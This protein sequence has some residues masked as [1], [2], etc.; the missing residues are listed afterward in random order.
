M[1]RIIL[2]HQ[3]L[4]QALRV[5]RL[6][7]RPTGAP[8]ALWRCPMS[9]SR[10]S[11]VAAWLA[12]VPGCPRSLRRLPL[13][14]ARHTAALALLHLLPAVPTK[15]CWAKKVHIMF[16]RRL[17]ARALQCLAHST[18]EHGGQC[19]CLKTFG[20][21]TGSHTCSACSTDC[22][23]A[24]TCSMFVYPSCTMNPPQDHLNGDSMKT[25][26]YTPCFSRH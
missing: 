22:C 19:S 26:V 2:Q 6:S 10:C 8:A 1:Q 12:P 9:P 15:H 25:E 21:F 4:P 5:Q 23:A 17:V 18:A 7:G 14:P 16:M 13:A 24:S 20:E 3:P 11:S